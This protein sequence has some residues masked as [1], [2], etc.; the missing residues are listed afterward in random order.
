MPEL[1]ITALGEQ[2]AFELLPQKGPVNVLMISAA[3][4]PSPSYHLLLH[5][6]Q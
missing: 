3:E 5:A 1:S 6:F 4:R 2:F